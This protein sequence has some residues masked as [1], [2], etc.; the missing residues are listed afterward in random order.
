MFPLVAM[1]MAAG[2]GIVAVLGTVAQNINDEARAQTAADSVALSG[3][4]S[5]ER[6][7]REVAQ[8]N[9]AQLTEFKVLMNDVRVKVRIGNHTAVA[10]ARTA[11]SGVLSALE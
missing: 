11:T 4:S 1:L 9:G 8:A 5:G 6:A 10:Q 7:S 3:V 2:M